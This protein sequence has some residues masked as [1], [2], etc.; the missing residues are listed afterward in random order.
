MGEK[1]FDVVALIADRVWLMFPKI[2][3]MSPDSGG[4]PVTRDCTATSCLGAKYKSEYI[5]WWHEPRVEYIV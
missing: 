5:S 1:S 2:A 3:I 4:H